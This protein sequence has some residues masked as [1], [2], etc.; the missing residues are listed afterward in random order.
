M[1]R[2]FAQWLQNLQ[3]T[4]PI[5][6]AGITQLLEHE[7]QA[8][9]GHLVE[10]RVRVDAARQS[11]NLSELLNVQLDLIPESRRRLRRDME[12]RERIFSTMNTTLREVAQGRA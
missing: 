4:R 3:K 1:S 10:L 7:W 8:L 5:I 9:Q 2:T 12:T 6:A 11:H